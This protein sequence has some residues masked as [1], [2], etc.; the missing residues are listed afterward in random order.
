MLTRRLEVASERC[1]SDKIKSAEEQIEHGAEHKSILGKSF[2]L[3]YIYT[4][5]FGIEGMHTTYDHTVHIIFVVCIVSY[6][7][8]IFFLHLHTEPCSNIY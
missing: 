7:F 6:I 1:M 8:F 3:I 5:Y 4:P 2:Y